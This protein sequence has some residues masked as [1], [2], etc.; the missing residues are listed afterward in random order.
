MGRST[1]NIVPQFRKRYLRY[2]KEQR[3]EERQL[4][5]LEQIKDLIDSA[6]WIGH[7]VIF[8][9]FAKT[10]I[11]RQELIDLDIQDLYLSKGYALLKPHA[12]RSNRIV[13]IDDECSQ[14]LEQYLN[15][16]KDKQN[17]NQSPLHRCAG[18]PDLQR[19]SL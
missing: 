14:V 3:H 7:K 4:I 19:C 15:W 2:Y 18:F 17:Q 1:K 10:G 9:F 12:K 5:N 11:R 8:T 6:E 13:F 16:R